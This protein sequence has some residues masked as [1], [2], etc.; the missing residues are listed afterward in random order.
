LKTGIPELSLTAAR[1]L[2]V[3][4]ELLEKKLLCSSPNGNFNHQISSTIL[5]S[6]DLILWET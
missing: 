3:G 2:I 6:S 5:A 4:T 1:I